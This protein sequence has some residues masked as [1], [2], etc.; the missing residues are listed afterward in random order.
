MQIWRRCLHNDTASHAIAD[1]RDS[2]VLS[3]MVMVA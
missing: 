1:F 2:M 3:M